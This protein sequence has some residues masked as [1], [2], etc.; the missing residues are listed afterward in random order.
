MYCRVVPFSRT[1]DSYGLVYFIPEHL[2]TNIQNYQIVEIPLRTNIEIAVV[3]EILLSLPAEIEP[4]KVKSLIGIKNDEIFLFPYQAQL[5]NFVT[6][7]YITPIHN[8]LGLFFPRNLRE[9]ILKETFWKIQ[10][11]QYKYITTKKPALSLAQKTAYTQ[12][13]NASQKKVLLYW[14]TGSGKTEIYREIISENLKNQK[15]TLLLIPE[16]ILWNQIGE[17]I[18]QMFWDDVLSISS[19]VPEA[20][21]TQYWVD[22]RSGN[23][24]IIVGTRS[25]LFYP[26]SNLATIIVD[27]EH[28]QSYVS[29]SAP[30][31]S[32][33]EIVS[34]I[35]QTL[36]IPVLFASGTPSVETMYNAMKWKYE[37][38]NLLEK[39]S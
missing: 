39:Y 1:F 14:V 12:I 25:S 33:R 10:P 13:R 8:A 28:D 17:R 18:K 30:R 3:L 6:T 16:I 9:K 2:E 20:K 36:D 7:Q 4:S 29:D 21:R 11:K 35:S 19:E 15:Q 26:Y 32:S 34:E 22:I 27:E 37:L 23:A 24:K 38:V 31:Y 5:V